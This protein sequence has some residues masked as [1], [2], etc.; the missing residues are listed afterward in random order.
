MPCPDDNTLA[1]FIGGRLDQ[2]RASALEAHIDQCDE[3]TAALAAIAGGRGAP[4]P[5]LTGAYEPGEHIGR[6]VIEARLGQ[7]AMGL[8]LRARDAELDRTVAIKVLAP[9]AAGETD[10]PMLA[11]RL[12][13]EARAMAAIDHPNVI[14]VYEVG[15]HG[16]HLYVVM[17]LCNGGTL[18]EWLEQHRPD[19]T[20]I[21]ARF[22]DAAAGLEAAHLAGLIHRD[23]KPD[24]VLVDSGVAKVADFGL[25]RQSQFRRDS[26]ATPLTISGALMGSPAYMAPEQHLGEPVGPAADQFA[27]CVALYEAIYGERPFAGETYTALAIN[28]VEGRMRPAPP[29]GRVPDHVY[30]ALVRGLARDPKQRWP[31]MSALRDALAAPSSSRREWLIAGAVIAGLAAAAAIAW[32][33]NHRGDSDTGSGEQNRAVAESKRR[34]AE[35]IKQ[36][37][38]MKRDYRPVSPRDVNMAIGTVMGMADHVPPPKWWNRP[39][40]CRGFD[41]LKRSAAPRAIWCETMMGAKNG[42]YTRWHDNGTRAEEGTFYNNQRVGR[43]I[44]WHDN[45]TRAEQAGYVVGERRTERIVWDRDGKEVQRE[46]APR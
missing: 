2:A 27:F 22:A 33:I 35:L 42:Y 4:P 10:A 38:A 5:S 18:R 11:E 19:P 44:R 41:L 46:P 36:M 9:E 21:L 8:V 43:W 20:S 28:V 17:Q 31:S 30:Q 16:A 37:E 40:P 26:T 39:L 13:R 15:S 7:G 29:R 45:G 1:G 12:R 24:N 34:S 14:T 23:F 25:V 3:C 6:F 32:G